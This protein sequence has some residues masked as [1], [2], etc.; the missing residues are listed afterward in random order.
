MRK[1]PHLSVYFKIDAPLVRGSK[2]ILFIVGYLREQ[3]Q[4]FLT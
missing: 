4:H 2:V 3:Q 1:Q